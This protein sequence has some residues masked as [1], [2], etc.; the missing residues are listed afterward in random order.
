MPEG[1]SQSAQAPVAP[2]APLVAQTEEL[3]R[4]PK[5][6]R[7]DSL[8]AL[9]GRLGTT[10]KGKELDIPFVSANQAG[11]TGSG[12][13]ESDRFHAGFALLSLT[14]A[15]DA[16]DTATYRRAATSLHERVQKLDLPKGEAAKI[17]ALA[18]DSIKGSLNTKGCIELAM[19]A[20][21]AL[22]ARYG[23]DPYRELGMLSAALLL[24]AQTK[25]S[26]LLTAEPFRQALH[27]L[28]RLEKPGGVGKKVAELA[29]LVAAPLD[30]AA[31]S[32]IEQLADD[33]Q[34]RF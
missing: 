21:T 14:V 2:P 12:G 32:K 1:A 22:N 30:N 20:D 4:K 10:A 17:L 15:C 5:M 3:Q 26:E 6:T 7:Q 27:R 18:E 28:A 19:K 16:G 23:D 33:I 9:A 24:S 29:A 25:N 11:F 13:A 34:K 31:W 8:L